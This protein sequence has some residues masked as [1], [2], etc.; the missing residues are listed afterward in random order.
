[1]E[2][3]F[4]KCHYCKNLLTTNNCNNNCYINNILNI[5]KIQYNEIRHCICTFKCHIC[6]KIT[7]PDCSIKCTNCFNCMCLKCIKDCKYRLY[8]D[9]MPFIFKC[10]ICRFFHFNYNEEDDYIY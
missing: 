1:M 5:D 7:C 3:I 4:I 9:I 6:Y 8:D 2:K 10:K